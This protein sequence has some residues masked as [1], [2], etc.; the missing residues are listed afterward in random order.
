[1]TSPDYGRPIRF[2]TGKHRGR[3][4]TYL[5][6]T[7][8]MHRV[9]IAGLPGSRAMW[10]STFVFTD[11]APSPPRTGSGDQELDQTISLLAAQ[12]RRLNL[13]P[14]DIHALIEQALAPDGADRPRR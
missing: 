9:S 13:Q 14:N 10:R 1:M 11:D 2:V 6:P 3:L 7:N 4:G 12:V 5:H 8:V